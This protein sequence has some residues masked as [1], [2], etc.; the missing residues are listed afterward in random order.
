MHLSLVWTRCLLIAMDSLV[1]SVVEWHVA[2]HVVE[3]D[4]DS[5][6]ISRV[7]L[8]RRLCSAYQGRQSPITQSEEIFRSYCEH[9]SIQS[10][11]NSY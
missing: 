9:Y 11:M 7:E 5:R 2:G 3:F 8:L 1:E 10:P 6:G 4:L